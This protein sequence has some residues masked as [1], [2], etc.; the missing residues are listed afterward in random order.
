M[1]KSGK[2]QEEIHQIR[3]LYDLV[4]NEEKILKKVYQDWSFSEKI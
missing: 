4:K 3:K 2:T 1:K